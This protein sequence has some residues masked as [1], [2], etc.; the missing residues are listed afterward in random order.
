[1]RR[2][3]GLCGLVAG[4]LVFGAVAGCGGDEG[5]SGDVTLTISSNAI[6]GGKNAEE[7]DWITNYVIPEFEAKM[8]DEG[9]PVTVEFEPS[10]VDDEDYKTRLALDM[11]TGEGADVASLDGIWIGEFAEAGYIEPVDELVGDE[12]D[13]WDGWDQ[14][15]EA[16]QQN[17]MFDDKLYG[18]PAGTDGR[19]IYFRKDL[20]EQAGLPADWQPTSWQEILDAAQS[21]KA[22]DG[23]TPLQVN[24][25]TAMGEATTMQGLL[26]LLAGTGQPIYDDGSWAGGGQ[27]MVDALTF[28]EQVY[29]EG[30][31]D[32]LLQ[33]EAKGR[34]ESFQLFADGKLGM[35][36]ES[37]YFWR[38]VINPEGIAP[39]KNREEVVG[40]A[41]IPAQEP[42]SGIDGQDFVSYSG[43]GARVINPG[44]DH[45]E[46]AWQ[47]LTFMN[48][49]EA[50]EEAL[51][52]SAR[53]TQ[54][55]DVN[56]EVLAGDP[57]LQFISEEVLP[58]TTY[59]PSLAIYPQV[60]VALQEATA[61]VVSGTDPQE[62]AT[63]YQSELEGIVGDSGDIEQ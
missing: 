29:G 14:I 59:R 57:M 35:L 38:D 27:G 16:V 13:D 18:I 12:V 7:A 6:A 52:G 58:I 2:L 9:T 19:V 60:S 54:R 34:D 42:G 33:Q 15:P 28:Y 5:G 26:P 56:E 62:A 48:S 22:Q 61:A 1:M 51:A 11:S 47:L 31:G 37:D 53:I 50:V 44:T 20:F 63:Q 10:G 23:V 17:A 3:N 25:G 46:E 45:P 39:L 55:E 21:L 36:I 32:P 49:A 30:L 40:W 43:G 4:V 8:Q 41:K 24:A